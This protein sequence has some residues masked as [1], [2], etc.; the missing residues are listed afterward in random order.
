MTDTMTNPATE[1]DAGRSSASSAAAEVARLR[2]TFASGRTQPL[3]WRLKQLDAVLRLME[4]NEDAIAK[5]LESDLGRSAFDSFFADVAPVVAE[6]KH[7]KKHLKSWVKPKRVPLPMAQKP[8][9]GWYSYEPLGV[10]FIIGPWNYPIHLVLAPLVGAFSVTRIGPA[11]PTAPSWT[12]AR[13][14]GAMFFTVS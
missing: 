9:R 13:V 5:A 2:A 1:A 4:E 8:G 11:T 12:W 7:A 10:V 3:E 6:A 14:A